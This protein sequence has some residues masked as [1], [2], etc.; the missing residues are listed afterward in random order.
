MVLARLGDLSRNPDMSHAE[1]CHLRRRCSASKTLR[2]HT[3]YLSKIDLTATNNNLGLCDGEISWT[4]SREGAYY[5]LLLL[6]IYTAAAY[7]VIGDD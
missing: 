2:N 6:P 5:V 7:M 3:F 4:A 1:S